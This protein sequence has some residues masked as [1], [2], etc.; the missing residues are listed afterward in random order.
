MAPFTLRLLLSLVAGLAGGVYADPST[1]SIAHGAFAGGLMVVALAHANAWMRIRDVALWMTVASVAWLLGL[2]AV[3]EAWHPSLRTLLE[4]RVGGF[5]IETSDAE[6]LDRPVLVDGVL[7]QDAAVG[8]SGVVLRLDVEHISLGLHPEAVRGGVSVVVGGELALQQLG[9]WTEGRRIRAPMSL[10]RPARYLNHGVPDMERALARRGVTL[11]GAI[12]SSA[13]VDVIGHGTPWQEWG[14]RMRARVRTAVAAHLSGGET[15]AAAVAT[16]ILIGDRAALGVDVERR[17]QQA[18]TYHVLAIS[19]GNIAILAGAVLGV[20]A[21][22]G[23]RGRGAALLAILGLAAYA[24]IVQ[25]SASVTRATSMALLYLAI[26]LIDQRTAPA[27]ALGLVVI[28]ILLLEP[29]A[30]TDVGLCLTAGATL[31][32]VLSA[33]RPPAWQWTPARTI[34]A[35]VMATMAAEIMLM[36]VSAL[37]FQRVTIAGIGLNFVAIPCMTAVQLGSMLLVATDA[38]GLSLAT[39]VASVITEWSVVGLLRSAELV[40]YAPW[41]TWRVPPPW[42]WLMAAY[43]GTL[44]GWW[45]ASRPIVDTLLRLWITRVC[46]A[47]AIALFAWIASDPPS[48]VRAHGDGRLHLTM[49][50]VGQGDC[51]LVTLPNGRTLLVDSGG[52]SLRGEFDVGDRVVGPALRARGVRRLDYFAITHGDPD[53][54]GGAR[55]VVRDFE[56]RE[57]WYGVPVANHQPTLQLHQEATHLRAAWRTLRRGDQVDLGDVE[58]HVR[59]PPPPD[60]ERQKVRN[61]DSLVFELRFGEVSLL[62]TGD[63]SRD[64]E[65]TLLLTLAPLP[66]VILKVPHHG[67]ATSSSAPFLEALRPLVATIGVGRG[68]PYGHPVPHVLDRYT[69]TGTTVFRTDQDGEIEV[70]TDGSSTDVRTFTGR[71]WKSP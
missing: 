44:T 70:T 52:V 53:H 39:D 57:V 19:G 29:L 3:D 45:L 31:G 58:L 4:Q 20:L 26:R 61:D 36:P 64:V 48:L 21:V 11:V 8:A 16:A 55:A 22:A 32:I 25:G 33:E 43:Y 59:H 7:R 30:I 28:G 17:L 13:L 38:L 18:G 50:D 27:N 47:L 49:I 35:L 23:W 24:V 6:Q 15:G 10:R 51:A 69:H 62:M 66:R 68:N 2:H 46:G 42:P 9:R 56:P 1:S 60:W 67:S 54:I 37:T 34:L 65:Q 71:R 63:I 12:K 40:D 14:A 41:L 5:A